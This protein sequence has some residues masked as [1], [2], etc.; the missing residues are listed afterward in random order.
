MYWRGVEIVLLPCI[1][2]VACMGGTVVGAAALHCQGGVYEW[3]S[4]GCSCPVSPGRRAWVVAVVG[5]AAPLALQ[6]FR[7]SS[8]KSLLGVTMNSSYS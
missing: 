8:L 6:L 4:G 5:A 1:S 7:N 3:C 2:R